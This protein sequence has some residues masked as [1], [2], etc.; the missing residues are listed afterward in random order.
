MATGKLLK[1][2]IRTTT[3][4]LTTTK[5]VE[6]MTEL[7]SD[8]IL[9]NEQ[10][11]HPNSIIS[12]SFP[13]RALAYVSSLSDFKNLEKL[14]LSLNSLTSLKG[15]ESCFNLKWL[16][17][18]HNK[19]LS[20]NGIEALT[21]LAVLN[22]GN[23]NLRSMDE[24]KNLVELRA[25][26]LN[27]NEI[28]SISGL[29]K[30]IELNTLGR[31]LMLTPIFDSIYF[32]LSRNPIHKVGISMAKLK[33]IVKISLSSCQLEDIDK[34]IKDCTGLEQLRLAHNNIKG[35]MYFLFLSF[36]QTLPAELAYTKKLQILDL[37]NNMISRWSD[38]E[39]L[40]SLHNLKNLNLLGNPIAEKVKLLK[41]VKKLV[42]SL[43]ILNSKRMD[44]LSSGTGQKFEDDVASRGYE[45][46]PLKKMK[47][48]HDVKKRDVS[49]NYNMGVDS[50]EHV[51]QK[52]VNF[53]HKLA[54]V[55]GLDEGNCYKGKE[56]SGMKIVAVEHNANVTNEK[57]YQLGEKRDCKKKENTSRKGK[58]SQASERKPNAA[59]NDG[60]DEQKK[61]KKKKEKHIEKVV[62]QEAGE[63]I[64]DRSLKRKV[65]KAHLDVIDDKETPFAELLAYDATK[66]KKPNDG[67]SRDSSQAI[68]NF[69]AISALVTYPEKKKKS[70][71]QGAGAS[72]FQFLAP[73]VGLGG[74]S[75]WSDSD[76]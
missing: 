29:D 42:P 50:D 69:E 73:E 56:R 65:K 10:T 23:N 28:A 24:V 53:D 30:L 37:G 62:L 36:K 16:S 13:H 18:H 33:S 19:L 46:K 72:V 68:G 47:K 22:A 55:G 5:L 38:L 41:K 6:S 75:A 48:D 59:Q 11:Q 57:E 8:Y 60:K 44:Q 17:V 35:V 12:L 40:S 58:I 74:A 71:N 51:N 76:N 2:I 3:P 43:Q 9:R 45:L 49:L 25:L 34:S 66:S 39:A 7:S 64:K 52:G 4:I 54:K 1:R 21:N 20:L 31:F 14:D 63:P 32:L 15:L 61:Q 67:Q 26:I 27:D 70:E